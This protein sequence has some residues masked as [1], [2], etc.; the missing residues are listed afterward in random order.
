MDPAFRV[1]IPGKGMRF[2]SFSTCPDPF[3]D[4]TSVLFKGY[5]KG[6]FPGI[7]Q[8]EREAHHSPLSSVEVKNEWSYTVSPPIRL[9]GLHGDSPFC[10]KYVYI[11]LII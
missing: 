7:Q 6:T 9:H 8:K 10:I 5:T 1:S 4:P 3:L 2:I 11:F